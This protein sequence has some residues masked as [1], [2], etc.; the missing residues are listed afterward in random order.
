[1]ATKQ[2]MVQAITQAA[3]GAAKAA[4]RAVKEAENPVI[5]T[6]LVAVI[7]SGPALNSQHFTGMQLTNTKNYETLRDNKHFHDNVV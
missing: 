7:P 3:I 2:N 6:R 5:T 1:M 4:I